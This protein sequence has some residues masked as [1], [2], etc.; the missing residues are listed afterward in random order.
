MQRGGWDL[1]K[2]TAQGTRNQSK[3]I[4]PLVEGHYYIFFL[5]KGKSEIKVITKFKN[6]SRESVPKKSAHSK[7]QVTFKKGFLVQG[8]NRMAEG[9]QQALARVSRRRASCKRFLI[10]PEGFAFE[11]KVPNRLEV[12]K[13]LCQFRAGPS[14]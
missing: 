3:R 13:R 5:K 11:H 2:P 7:V 10:N 8:L 9:A 1:S 14:P 4:S 12:S 6:K